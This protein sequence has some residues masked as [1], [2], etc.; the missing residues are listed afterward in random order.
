MG[1][2][3]NRKR[4]SQVVTQWPAFDVERTS[5]RV[6]LLDVA[7]RVLLLLT[8]DP[9]MP[10][11]GQWWELPG[12]GVEAGESFAQTAVRELAEETGFE[13]GPADVGEPTWTRDSTY[14]RRHVRTYQHEVVVT[15][16]S[17]LVAPDPAIDGRTQSELEEYIG[18]RWWTPEE[19]SAAGD[20]RFFPGS[21]AELLP[22]H[23]A[24]EVID[25][26]FDHW[27]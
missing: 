8:A 22:R 9:E 3:R 18:H 26:P 6:V 5:V 20:T 25:E 15:V 17:A 12:G 11:V 24:G 21:L 7:G 2:C 27:N 19:I 4:P 10:E 14:L 13:F 23:L 16:R 1:Q